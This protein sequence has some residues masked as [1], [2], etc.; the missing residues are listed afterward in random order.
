MYNIYM[1]TVR[2]FTL[3][4]LFVVPFFIL[5][6]TSTPADTL[7][8]QI[9][10]LVMDRMGS[11]PTPDQIRS[12]GIRDNLQTRI[13]PQ[14]P[15][16]GE[17]VQMSIESFLTDLDKATITWTLNGKV[18]EKG[19]GKSLFTFKNGFSVVI[20]SAKLFCRFC[21]LTSEDLSESSLI[22]T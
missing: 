13:N 19:M 20:L 12:N 1:K 6:Q 11:L 3:V 9:D 22:I 8:K 18:A 15:G 21:K 7:Q 14:N 16:P 2:Y 4:S 10:S 17:N 5:A